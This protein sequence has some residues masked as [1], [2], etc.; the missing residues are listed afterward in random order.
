[1]FK[2]RTGLVMRILNELQSIT[3]MFTTRIFNL[4]TISAKIKVWFLSGFFEIMD[5]LS[6]QE[7]RHIVRVVGNDIPGERKTIVGLTQI[8]GIGQNFATAVIDV[9]GI[10]PNSNIGDLT[11][12]DVESIEKIITDPVTANF[13]TWFL[14]RRKDINTGRAKSSINSL[15]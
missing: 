12:K 5:Y 7:Y 2:E 15:H 11:D 8:K 6:S 1:M 9:L 14:N 13:P 3:T 10:N 4:I